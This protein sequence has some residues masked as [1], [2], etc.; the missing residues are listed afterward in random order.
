MS[1]S[2]LVADDK[3]DVFWGSGIPTPI[4]ETRRSIKLTGYPSA[5]VDLQAQGKGRL[6]CMKR[7]S[8]RRG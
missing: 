5:P 1:V 8:R 3:T 6:W 2:I 4:E 7:G